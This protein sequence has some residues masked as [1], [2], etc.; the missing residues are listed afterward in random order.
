MKLIA[1]FFMLMGG[2]MALS[3]AV[4]GKGFDGRALLGVIFVATALLLWWRAAA[5]ARG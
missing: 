1:I 2:F 4:W 3:S 5:R